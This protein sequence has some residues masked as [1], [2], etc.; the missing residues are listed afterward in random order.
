MEKNMLPKKLKKG[1]TIAIVSPSWGGPSVF[2]HV[3]ENGLK[4]LEEWGLKIKE[5]PTARAS[6]D[7]LRKNPEMRAKDINDAFYNPE[8]KAI[9]TSIGGDDSVRILP[10]IDREIIKNNP[11]IF[12]GYSDATTLHV[13]FNQLGLVT[14][15]GPSI[16]AGFSQMKNLPESFEKHV[17]DMLFESS[18]GHEYV[19]YEEYCEGVEY[20]IEIAI[21]Y[22]GN[23]EIL[24]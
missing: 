21:D 6:A 7:Y 8:V 1:D 13:F 15:Y 22:K 4:I 12:L 24:P 18:V 14:F 11:K 3:Y 5:Y 9:L 23:A 19:P 17:K 16:M 10:Y 20:G 2:P